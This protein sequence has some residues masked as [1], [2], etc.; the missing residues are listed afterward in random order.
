[1]HDSTKLLGL[2][3]LERLELRAGTLALVAAEL[4]TTADRPGTAAPLGVASTGSASSDWTGA[5]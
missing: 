4:G 5:W 3:L 1:M 2:Q